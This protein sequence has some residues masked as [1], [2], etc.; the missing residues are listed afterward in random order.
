MI[1]GYPKFECSPGNLI[2][3]DEKSEY[4]KIEG[5]QEEISLEDQVEI[6]DPL[7]DKYAIQEMV[8]DECHKEDPP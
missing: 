6:T 8:K 3:D 7:E 5:V 1:D 4:E 2:T